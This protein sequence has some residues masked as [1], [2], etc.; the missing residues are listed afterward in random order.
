[1]S[2][3]PSRLR[4]LSFGIAV[5]IFVARPLAAQGVPTLDSTVLTPITA[6]GKF[7][8]FWAAE[9]GANG[10]QGI[11]FKN[12]SPDRSITITSWEVY[13]C[14]KLAAG[15]CGKRD[16]GPTIK[17]GKTVRLILVRGFRGGTEGFS[18]RY[19]FTHQWTD[20]LGP[21]Q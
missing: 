17:P 14:I 16:K 15:I 8:V 19:R 13:D 3:Y 9:D 11:Y 12:V 10:E 7:L 20:E 2:S 4:A 5:A 1:M 21:G 18:Y 6:S